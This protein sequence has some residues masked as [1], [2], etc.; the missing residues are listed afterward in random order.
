MQT[1]LR[2]NRQSKN[3]RLLT[4]LIVILAIVAI[5]AVLGLIDLSPNETPK[6]MTAPLPAL[7]G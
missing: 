7:D 5:V 3:K 2:A 4:Y 6:T 1:T